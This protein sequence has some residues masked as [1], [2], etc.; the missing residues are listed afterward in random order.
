MEAFLQ[1]EPLKT[2][3]VQDIGVCVML[4]YGFVFLCH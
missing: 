1:F 4:N 2:K 3:N